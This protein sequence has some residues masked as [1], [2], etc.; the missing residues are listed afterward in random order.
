MEKRLI[1]LVSY[2]IHSNHMNYG[3]VLHTY[4]FQQYLKKKGKQSVVIDYLPRSLEKYNL[5][6]PLFNIF[7]MRNLRGAVWCCLNWGFLGLF[8]NVRKFRKFQN[9]FDKYYVKTSFEYD[10]NELMSLESIENLD[11]DT[12]VCES[13]VIWKLYGNND[14]DDIFFLNAPFAKNKNKIAYSP[15]IGARPLDE[16]EQ[17]RIVSMTKDYLAISCREKEGAEYLQKIL[18]RDVSW[19]LDP[20]LLL[21]S[22]DYD[23]ITAVPK[24]RNYLLVYNCMTNDKQMLLEAAKLAEQLNLEMIEI[25]NYSINKIRFKHKVKTDLGIEEWLG[26]FKYADYVVCNAFHGCCFSVLF[27]K[28]FTL[29]QRDGSDYR[30]KSIVDGLGLTDRLIPYY[31]KRIPQ[32]MSLIDYKNVNMRLSALRNQSFDFIERYI[33]QG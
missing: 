26:Y 27:E 33:V 20:T 4:A 23:P 10:Y 30:M 21:D 32:T 22:N 14:F 28:Q 25:S 13:D 18:K 11:I 3:A 15:S 24:E 19:V 7:S 2:N 29:F 9:F 5:K 31:D 16:K 17:E 1:G 6:Y 12:Y 8:Q